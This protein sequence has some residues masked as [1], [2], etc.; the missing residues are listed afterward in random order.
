VAAASQSVAVMDPIAG[1]ASRQMSYRGAGPRRGRLGQDLYLGV[2]ELDIY[3]CSGRSALR[4]GARQCG[5]ESDFPLFE[6]SGSAWVSV[7]RAS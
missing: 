2:V 6:S 3:R 5:E 4:A 1:V 7:G